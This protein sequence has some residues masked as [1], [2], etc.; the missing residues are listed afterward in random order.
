MGDVKRATS[1]TIR[2]V[3]LH[4]RF[5]R[6]VCSHENDKRGGKCCHFS[7]CV[8]PPRRKDM[9][10]EIACFPLPIFSRK[11]KKTG[12]TGE[13]RLCGTTSPLAEVFSPLHRLLE[14]SSMKSYGEEKPH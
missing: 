12:N 6:R 9:R 5:F 10:L 7:G 11:I 8:E 13:E 3:A 14:G 2:F 1:D 4:A